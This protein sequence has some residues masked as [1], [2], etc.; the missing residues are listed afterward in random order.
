MTV[1]DCQ[2]CGAATDEPTLC[3]PCKFIVMEAGA[4]GFAVSGSK[5]YKLKKVG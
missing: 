4:A 1:G 2:N 5:F 3:R